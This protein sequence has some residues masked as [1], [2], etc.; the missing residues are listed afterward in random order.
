MLTN[1]YHV[2]INTLTISV[3]ATTATLATHAT[4]FTSKILGC[5]ILEVATAA[6]PAAP[7]VAAT[8]TTGEVMILIGQ[9]V[10]PEVAEITT[11]A[12]TIYH[13]AAPMTPAAATAAVPVAVESAAPLKES[14]LVI[15]RL[16]HARDGGVPA[17]GNTAPRRH[18]SLPMKTMPGMIQCQAF[19]AVTM[20]RSL[21]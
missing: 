11:M 21:A 19:H 18:P 20:M 17:V 3:L 1:T 8:A 2:N 16:G 13:T 14:A 5:I 10:I 4:E 15:G 9:Q 6:A 7:A 12:A